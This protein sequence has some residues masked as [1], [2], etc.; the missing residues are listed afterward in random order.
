LTRIEYLEV[1][2]EAAVEAWNWMNER[3]R[4]LTKCL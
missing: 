3:R 1:E 2:R 4:L